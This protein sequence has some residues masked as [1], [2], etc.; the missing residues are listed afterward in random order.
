[1]KSLSLKP[2]IVTL[3]S[4]AALAGGQAQTSPPAIPAAAD[5]DTIKAAA[6]AEAASAQADT[7]AAPVLVN[8]PAPAAEPGAKP[9]TSQIIP[10]GTIQFP[11]ADLD[12]VLEIYADLVNRTILR[13][14]A[15]PA[16]T[17]TLMTQTDLTKAEAIQALDAVLALNGISMIDIGEKFVKAVPM[18]Q[19]GQEGAPVS[20]LGSETLPDL[21]Q[22]VSHVVQLKNVKASEVVPALQPFSKIPN[23]VLAIES[24]NILILRDFTENVKR[25]L[26]MIQRIDVTVDSNY[27]S[28]VIPI[29]YALAADIASALNSLSTGGGTTSVGGSSTSSRVGSSSRQRTGGAPGNP[30]GQQQNQRYGG[31]APQQAATAPGGSFTDRLRSIINKASVSGDLEILGQTRIIADE[32]TNSLLIFASKQDMAMIKDI[33]DKL[34]VVLAQVLIE[35]LVI[36]VGLGDSFDWG[37]SYLQTGKEFNNDWTGAGG[38]FNNVNFINPE[39]VK[40]ATNLLG[41]FSYYAKYKDDLLIAVTAAAQDNNVSILSRPRVQTSHAVEA[42]IFVGETR[43]YPTGSSYGGVYGGYSS[44]QQQRIGIE[45]NVLPLINPDGLVVMDISQ[46]IQSVGSE[47]LIE[48]VGLV[49]VTQDRSANAKVA[50]KSGETIVLGGFIG[51]DQR[52]SKSGVPFLK[53]IPGLGILFRAQSDSKSR[54]ELMI[55]IKP[56]VLPTPEIA[57]KVA[58]EEKN[59]MPGV[60]GAEAALTRDY[61]EAMRKVS[62]QAGMAQPGA[63]FENAE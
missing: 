47:V 19:A 32:R 45:L 33:I 25:M 48:N 15:L 8:A 58:L 12:Q 62:K 43:P 11:A 63:G 55:F 50:V 21:G 40:A 61:E 59:K 35:A 34:D 27:S 9:A 10:K 17:I 56:T 49:P 18:A 36:E 57:A 46:T 28:E 39:N 20:S 24:S 38:V 26:E 51:A 4:L 60:L 16:G 22:Y 42:N 54:N 23:S 6:L 7:T 44:I 41:G 37:I 2:L 3:L 53:D 5:L 1:M 13:P 52:S 30:Y 31:Y 14:A 29:K